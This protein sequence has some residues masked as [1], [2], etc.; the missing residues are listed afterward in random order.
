M[1]TIPVW[2]SLPWFFHP[3]LSEGDQVV[4]LDWR[5]ARHAAGAKRLRPGDRLV[6]FDGGGA[7]ATAEFQEKPAEASR[8]VPVR[9]IECRRTAPPIPAL[10][11]A[12]ALPKGDRQSTMLGMATQ[13]T[14][15]SFTPLTCRRSVVRCAPTF[16]QRARRICLEACK[17]TH[18]AHCPAIHPPASPAAFAR[19]AGEERKLVLLADPRGAAL[20]EALPPNGPVQEYAILIGPEGGFVDGEIEAVRDA[21]GRIVRLSPS[22]LRI[23]TAA[24][25]LLAALLVLARPCR[26]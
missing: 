23:E 19:R 11:L 15:A 25:A 26:D 24:V 17:Q 10:H 1:N 22:I 3:R 4:E 21:G 5:E 8:A 12:A 18:L 2:H 14:M 20:S 16:P 6:L 9:I 7:L 13:L